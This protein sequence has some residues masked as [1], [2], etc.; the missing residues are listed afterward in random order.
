[1]T[2]LFRRLHMPPLDGATAWLNSEP[3]DPA[4]LRGKVVLVDFWTLTC[5]NWLRTEPWIRAWSRAYRDDG[6]VVIGVHTPEFGFE[7]DLDLVRQAVRERGIDHPV[8]IDNGYRV[9]R[10][11]DNHYWPAL[12]FVDAQ[13]RI[14]HHHFGEGEYEGS[15]MVLQMLLREADRDVD[16]GLVRIEPGGA[17]AQADWATLGSPETYLG[18]GR[19][20]GFAS[21]GDFVPDE[22]HGYAAPPA[23]RRNE[24]ALSGQWRVGLVPAIL[25]E[26]GGTVSFQFHARDLH[27]VMGPRRGQPPVRFQVRLDGGRPGPAHGIDVDEDGNGTAEFQRMYQLIRQPPPIGDRRLDVEFLDAGVEVFVFTFG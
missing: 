6:L 9:W 3:L 16:Q 2:T 27:L 13:G 23:L 25:G 21:P 7:H 22:A 15:E 24:W 20:V 10:A 1:M 5:I 11:F 17:E 19:A 18:Y 14:R 4:G 26:A 12:Y 8:A